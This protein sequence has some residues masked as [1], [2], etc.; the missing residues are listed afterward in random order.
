MDEETWPCHI[1]V[2]ADTRRRT[3]SLATVT[4]VPG[5]SR[6]PFGEPPVE[7][8]PRDG[9]AVLTANFL[10]TDEADRLLASLAAEIPWEATTLV[11]FGS[12]VAEPRLSAWTADP[13]MSYRYSGRTRTV[14]PWSV[15]LEVLRRRITSHTGS[16]FNGV[17]ANL[18]RN[19]RDHMGWHADD[20]KS[21]GPAPVI[22][23]VSLG[24][25]RRFELRH[26]DSREVVS[27]TLPHG[28]LLVMSG[29]SQSCWTHR[30]PRALRI[31]EPRINLTFRL[32]VTPPTDAP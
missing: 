30:L 18:Y 7:L 31:T 8:L 2:P 10:P 26:R 14:H 19:G 6:L 22:A 21:L 27:C 20:E 4:D 32:L 23:S 12:E 9:S 13:G 25:E 1:V 29:A 5:A 17:L 28:S 3:P 16:E 24:A 11:M 15:D